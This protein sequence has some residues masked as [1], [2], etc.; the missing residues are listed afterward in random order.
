MVGRSPPLALVVAAGLLLCGFSVGMQFDASSAPAS[1]GLN[2]ALDKLVSELGEDAPPEDTSAA[3]R[4]D[5][6]QAE[7]KLFQRI[8]ALKSTK[9]ESLTSLSGANETAVIER[10]LGAAMHDAISKMH[11]DV[12][13]NQTDPRNA[14]NIKAIPHL[15]DHPDHQNSK[16]K[17]LRLSVK[18]EATPPPAIRHVLEPIIDPPKFV[19]FGGAVFME[20]TAN[21]VNAFLEENPSELV[22]FTQPQ[23]QLEPRVLISNII[24]GSV[25][26]GDKTLSAGS[27]LKRF[28]GK[29][30]KSFR[31]VCRVINS[32]PASIW[33]IETESALAVLPVD[34]VTKNSEHNNDEW[35]SK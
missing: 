14:S 30:I 29:E 32:P 8:G 3:A 22:E 20:L 4:Q 31:D 34:T 5:I 21:L 28:N 33:S 23:N 18:Y 6:M 26:A 17:L 25:A 1:L 24:P 15:S 16:G 2:S 9:Q 11:P 19:I 10:E 7:A 12:R 27:L 13:V 35:C